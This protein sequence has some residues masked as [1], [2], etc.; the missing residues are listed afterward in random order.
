LDLGWQYQAYKEKGLDA[1]DEIFFRDHP[2]NWHASAY[3]GWL[4]IKAG[5]AANIYDGNVLLLN[6]EQQFV[7]KPFYEK[8][9]ALNP[10]DALVA[11]LGVPA[12]ALAPLPSLIGEVMGFLTENPIPSPIALSFWD[13]RTATSQIGGDLADYGQRWDWIEHNMG[14]AFDLLGAAGRQFWIDSKLQDLA[15][16]TRIG[17]TGIDLIVS[18]MESV[19][20]TL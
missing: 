20:I 17:D 15:D 8:I 3:Q 10:V 6:I 9:S 7:A 18:A 11:S 16:A 13:Y 19:L 12:A 2:L 14:P 5:G 1:I 4:K